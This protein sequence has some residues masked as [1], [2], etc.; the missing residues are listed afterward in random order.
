MKIA[1]LSSNPSVLSATK[2][3]F[4]QVLDEKS[5][6]SITKIDFKDEKI[7]R[8]L[9]DTKS[10]TVTRIFETEG[11]DYYVSVSIGVQREFDDF[12]GYIFSSVADS[13]KN[14]FGFGMS[15]TFQIPDDF[16]AQIEK[17]I[18]LENNELIGQI[19]G[20][21]YTMDKFMTESIASA[22]I[23][24]HF[25]PIQIPENAPPELTKFA[26]SANPI[27][28][29]SLAY[30]LKTLDFSNQKTFDAGKSSG[31]LESIAELT[32][33]DSVNEDVVANG[34]DALSH[35]EV[36]VV[37]MA[38]GQGSRLRAP[39]PKALIE[40]DIPSKMT[41]L[42][43]QLRRI[44]KL[45][46]MLLSYGQNPKPIPVY[47]LTSESTHS[48]IAAYLLQHRN[49]G[50]TH[51]M[52]VKQKQLPARKLSNG[53]FVLSNPTKVCA[54]PNGNGAVFS[55][56]KESGALKQMKELGIRYV[57]IHP[58]DNA[59]AR[60]ADPFFVGAMIYEEGDAAIKVIRKLP[61]EKMGTVCKRDGKTV[62]IEYSE[63]PEGEESL[64]PYG[65][66]ALQ[67]Y[68]IEVIE[69]VAEIELP[70]HIANKKEMVLNDKGE[71]ELSDVQKFE[72]FI[73]DAL[74]YCENVVIVE[75]NRED[76]FA[77]VKNSSGA[78]TDSPETA[79]DL[80][81]ALHRR[82]AEENEITLE[83]EGQLEFLP[84]TTYGGE[85]L[86]KMGLVG[87]TLTL[88]MMI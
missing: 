29:N 79:R 21:F 4:Q 2:T 37:I 70:Y 38:G 42:E 72:R 35:G 14:K 22:L 10:E 18:S 82:W 13:T 26:N 80:L 27:D 39:L 85:G 71:L 16:T 67:L 83:G 81:L 7:Y 64:Y 12:Y 45:H 56:L 11:F 53:E 32:D 77:P 60:P 25:F 8:T 63:I 23:P 51:V 65:N 28:R 54:A 40:L 5:Q 87:S 73:F 58:I 36:A 24:F 74:E 30:Q 75:C 17:G 20:G 76:E 47:I 57:D 59:L 43:I 15:P 44:R 31:K 55:A 49:F 66:T 3:I 62:I 78:P 19:T 84:E 69:K 46:N 88:P 86:D 9:E 48:T 61:K 34:I 68:S 50:L 33:Y 6:P 52:L 1:V 41:L